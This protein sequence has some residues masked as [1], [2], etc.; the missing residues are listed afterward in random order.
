MHCVVAPLIALSLIMVS[1]NI[2]HAQDAKSAVFLRHGSTLY[3]DAVPI[4]AFEDD[5]KGI[6][7]PEPGQHALTFNKLEV[8]V[9]YRG[10]ELGYF[11]REDYVFNFSADTMDIIYMDKNKIRI[12]DDKIYDIYL[13]AQHIKTEGWRLGYNLEF[14]RDSKVRLSL[15]YFDAEDLLYG[16]L[17]GRITVDNGNI[18]GG[19]LGVFYNYHEDY[20][21]RRKNIQTAGGTGY[22]MDLEAD[23]RFSGGWQMKIDLYDLLG[24]IRW[25]AAPYTQA[26][27]ASTA[28]YYDSNG[29]ARRDPMMT[30]IASYHNFTQNLPTHYQVSVAKDIIGPWGL[31]Y[32]REKY[33]RVD[34]DRAFL[35]YRIAN[36]W[37]LLTGYDFAMEAVWIA[38]QG[39]AFSLQVAT[40]DWTLID[41]N[42]LV[43]QLA[44]RWAF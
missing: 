16:S 9:A 1:A 28:T 7:K 5:L 10:L 19:N 34:F 4:K 39:D 6:D 38:L 25:D 12:P 31:V 40:D 24:K 33:H 8:G 20:L 42:A 37:S 17:E 3:S 41:S 35:R 18:D 2:A 32:T 43:L 29:Y 11:M 22:S 21:L 13:E 26:D 36:E 30:G 15:N 23:I 27:I 44:G 14:M